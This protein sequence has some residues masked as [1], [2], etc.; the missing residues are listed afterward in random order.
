MRIR[1]IGSLVLGSTTNVIVDNTSLDAPGVGFRSRTL[2]SPI[3][4]SVD[5]AFVRSTRQAALDA[6]N[7]FTREI[8]SYSQRRASPLFVVAGGIRILIEDAA[9]NATLS[10]YLQDGSVTLLSVEQSSSGVIAKIRLSG[11]LIGSFITNSYTAYTFSLLFPYE[12]R[13]ISLPNLSDNALYAQDYIC[14][15]NSPAGIYNALIAIEER[16]TS[17]AQS[18]IAVINPTSATSGITF[19]NWNA[20]WMTGTRALFSS[21]TGGTITYVI[22]ALALPYDAYRLFIEIFTPS[23]PINARYEISWDGQ[24]TISEVLTSTR[25]WYTPGVYARGF[26]GATVSLQLINVPTNTLVMPLVFIPIDG[27]WVHNVVAT[28]SFSYFHSLYPQTAFEFPLYA[29]PGGVIYGDPNIITSRHISIFAGIMQSN[30]VGFS[31]NADI[32]SRRIEPAAFV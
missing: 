16:E 24:P 7:A 2:S 12:R 8:Y 3:P 29:P 5:L 28:P 11:T 30:L 1:Q 9:G 22:N 10:S 31:M 27:V 23:T 13:T 6:I 14:D 4:F 15:I 18:R 17:A 20:G 26:Y 25:S 32:R 19:Q 21:A